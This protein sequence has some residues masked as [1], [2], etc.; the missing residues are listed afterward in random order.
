MEIEK[1]EKGLSKNQYYESE[2]KKKH[3]FLHHTAGGSAQGAINW[4]NSAPDHVSTAYIIDRAG[5]VFECFPPQYWAY[6]LGLKGGTEIEK[7]SIQ[8]ELV[9]WGSLLERNGK[10]YTYT[11]EEVPECEVEDFSWMSDGLWRGKRYYQG[12]TD[13]QIDSLGFLLQKLIKDFKIELQ[14]LHFLKYVQ[15]Y[16]PT[17]QKNPQS[18]IWSH[19]T[20]RKDKSDIIPQKSLTNLLINL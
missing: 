16:R 9:A 3:I 5:R 7:A 13:E 20:V 1:F 14:P 10:F 4:W 11:K 18:G 6:A 19:S 15:N 17:W 12:Y 8:I 2:Y